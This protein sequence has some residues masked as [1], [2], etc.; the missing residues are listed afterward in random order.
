M[1]YSEEE[2]AMWIEDW[3]QS[4][5]SLCA[6]AKANGLNVTTLTNWV[7]TDRAPHNFI[8]VKPQIA[9]PADLP[10]KRYIPEIL[11]EK[12]DV[13]IHIPVSIDRTELRAVIESLGCTL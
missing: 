6:Y 10:V 7:K 9:E 13:R 3:K 1:K 12:G 11:I 2:K 5:E 8:E 4:G